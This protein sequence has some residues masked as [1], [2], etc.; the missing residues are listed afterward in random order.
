MFGWNQGI[1]CLRLYDDVRGERLKANSPSP[2][3]K[4][5]VKELEIISTRI[6]AKMTQLEKIISNMSKGGS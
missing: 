5:R 1:L 4:K 3:L 2:A 6:E